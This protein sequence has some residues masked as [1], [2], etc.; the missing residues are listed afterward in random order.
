LQ[1]ELNARLCGE[2]QVSYYGLRP[3]S[4]VL[5]TY[6]ERSLW[7]RY[8]ELKLRPERAAQKAGSP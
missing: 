8:V 6:I 4:V 3:P 2:Y 7:D 5:A 1:E